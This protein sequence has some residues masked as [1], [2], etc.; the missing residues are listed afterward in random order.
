MPTIV[1]TPGYFQPGNLTTIPTQVDW[2]WLNRVQEEQANVVLASGQTLNPTLYNQMACAVSIMSSV[3]SSKITSALGFTP[4][5][6]VGGTMSPVLIITTNASVSGTLTT[7]NLNV[8]TNASFTN[9]TFTGVISSTGITNGSNAAT[10]QV[11]EYVSATLVGGS[12]TALTTAVA[13]DVTSISLTAG[14]WEIWGNVAF[15]AGTATQ[16]IILAGWISTTSATI[17]AS[18]NNGCFTNISGVTFTNTAYG[19]TLPVGRMRLSLSSTTTVYLTAYA[20]FTVSTQAVYG[21][22]G[23]RRCR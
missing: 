18:P 14:D 7:S 8:T 15:Y 4:L 3:T 9:A 1:G 23:A 19:P 21:F 10:G 2:G 20:A 17:P 11:G 22:I 16:S 13:K 5:S 12:A 6:S